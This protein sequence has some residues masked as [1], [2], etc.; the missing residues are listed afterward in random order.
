MRMPE[1]RIAQ[2]LNVDV[3]NIRLKRDLLDRICPEAVQIL[4]DKR[5]VAGALREL[6]KVK[7]MRQIEIAELLFSA[8]NFTL[9]YVQYLV[10]ATAPDQLVEGERPS[11]ARELLADD[12]RGMEHEMDAL[13]KQF[14][15]IEE[16]HG[17]NVLSL[18]LMVGY[19]KKLLDN[20]RIVRYLSQNPCR[21]PGRVPKACG[22]AVT[23]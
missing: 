22:I 23:V 17:K 3:R 8:R 7:P 15:L 1:S 13:A 10:A 2:S 18:V 20:A 6:R 4:K 5:V 16:S 12:L 19:L 11:E 14:K 9:G 21:D